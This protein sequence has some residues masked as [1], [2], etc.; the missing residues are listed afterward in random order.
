MPTLFDDELSQLKD[1]NYRKVEGGLSLTPY[2]GHGIGKTGKGFGDLLSGAFKFIGDNKDVIGTLG[3]LGSDV[4]RIVKTAKDINRED[5]KLFEI[6][7]IRQ[8]KERATGLSEA[9]KKII[10]DVRNKALKEGKGIK[11]V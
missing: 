7:R 5:E 4:A 9:H 1:T 11:I 6:K 2:S 10:E 8:E 3:G